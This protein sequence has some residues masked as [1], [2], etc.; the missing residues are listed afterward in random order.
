MSYMK[1]GL[2][3]PKGVS[4]LAWWDPRS[5]YLPSRAS[6]LMWRL[7]N[8]AT[9]FDGQARARTWHAVSEEYL[10]GSQQAIR[11]AFL[12]GTETRCRRYDFSGLAKR[13]QV[14]FPVVSMPLQEAQV[15]LQDE[16]MQDALPGGAEKEDELCCRICHLTAE[17]SDSPLIEPCQCAGSIRCAHSSCL[18]DWLKHTGAAAQS[19]WRCDL[20]LS[21]FRVQSMP[22]EPPGRRT[23]GIPNLSQLWWVSTLQ[24]LRMLHRS[25]LE[26]VDFQVSSECSG[27]VSVLLT[28]TLQTL[29]MCVGSAL[30][31][32]LYMVANVVLSPVV[33]SAYDI[34]KWPLALPA[35]LL[36]II[37][38]SLY[39]VLVVIKASMLLSG[40]KSRPTVWCDVQEQLLIWAAEMLTLL[41]NIRLLGLLTL[42]SYLTADHLC[43]T[44]LG[45]N[46]L[47]VIE[48]PILGHKPDIVSFTS[49]TMRANSPAELVR[50]A[51][52][53]T[54]IYQ[55]IG[56]LSVMVNL[57]T[58]FLL[59]KAA[60]LNARSVPIHL[61]GWWC[62]T[63]VRCKRGAERFSAGMGRGRSEDD[64]VWLR[65]CLAS[66]IRC[67]RM[68]DGPGS[69]Q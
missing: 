9:R 23:R 13:L 38:H 6:T 18:I 40:W 68:I 53:S 51:V 20:C 24:A 58:I 45:M 34:L 41:C 69:S 52:T 61:A 10:N 56:L 60:F 44:C 25:L 16:E 54:F 30:A 12:F 59:M 67:I 66:M 14:F 47:L 64:Q 31:N 1:R 22:G 26:F 19:E 32:V 3:P 37:L 63:F 62:S 5:A 35:I 4:V 39:T 36:D 27:L 28:S 42:V 49:F 7:S 50:N 11:E 17:E 55:A 8:L 15:Q 2:R 33:T 65:I 46:A 57:I 29:L 48:W 43:R 21:T